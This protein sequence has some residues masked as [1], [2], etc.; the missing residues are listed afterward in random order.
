MKRGKGIKDLDGKSG[1]MEI[2][3][4]EAEPV[5]YYESRN[6][7]LKRRLINEGRCDERLKDSKI[8][9]RNLHA[10]HTLGCTTK[11]TRNT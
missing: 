6:R 1:G 8:K 4:T 3:M 10:S 2:L 5:V 7:E 9:L 11:Q